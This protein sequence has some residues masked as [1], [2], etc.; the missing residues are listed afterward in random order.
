LTVCTTLDVA[1]TLVTPTASSELLIF[2]VP[3]D[4]KMGELLAWVRHG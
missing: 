1:D 2:G 3:K 4:E